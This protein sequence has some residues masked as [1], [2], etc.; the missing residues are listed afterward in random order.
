MVLQP[1]KDQ[2]GPTNLDSTPILE[3]TTTVEKRLAG[4]ATTK[5]SAAALMVAVLHIDIESSST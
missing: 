5:A 3:E 4:I 1:E 2:A